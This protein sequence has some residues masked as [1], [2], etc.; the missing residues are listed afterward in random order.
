MPSADPARMPAAAAAALGPRT[1][2]LLM[3]HVSFSTGGAFPVA[4]ICA[5][6]RSKPDVV[7]IIDGA[8]SVGAIPVNVAEIKP[9]FYAF[10]GYKYTL[11]LEGT[12]A[13]YASPRAIAMQPYRVASHT[14]AETL[15]EWKLRL[16]DDARRFEGTSTIDTQAYA[17]QG[18]SL[19]YLAGLGD[20]LVY[21]ASA[22]LCA[23]FRQG[24][25]NLPDIEL[26]TPLAPEHAAALIVFRVAGLTPREVCDKLLQRGMIIR[27]VPGDAVG[28]SFHFYHTPAEVAGLL[29]GLARIKTG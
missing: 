20:G 7:T 5:A 14:V 6:V 27:T 16:H 22:G 28:A 18:D 15:P 1:R 4:A 19:A 17:A 23:Q 10:P 11:G 3:T 8:Q 13:L 9:D 24:M 2:A 29:D 12:A 26:V 25:L 21:A